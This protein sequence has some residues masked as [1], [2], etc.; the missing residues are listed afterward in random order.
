MQHEQAVCGSGQVESAT[1]RVTAP[2]LRTWPGGLGF[3]RHFVAGCRVGF[4][5]THRVAFLGTGSVGWVSRH[6]YNGSLGQDV[7]L[8]RPLSPYLASRTVSD[9]RFFSFLPVLWFAD[10][11][12]TV[13]DWVGH[14][15]LLPCPHLIAS[16]A[17]LRH[18]SKLPALA[19]G[20]ECCELVKAHVVACYLFER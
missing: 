3:F 18:D 7:K 17:S 13:P 9:A 14:A 10:S 1:R 8:A 2:Y 19:R 20:G 6:C 12:D 4:I 5:L 11:P 16:S 15:H